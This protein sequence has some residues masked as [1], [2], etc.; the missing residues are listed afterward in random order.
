MRVVPGL[1]R[2]LGSEGAQQLQHYRAGLGAGDDGSNIFLK[3]L[4]TIKNK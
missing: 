1:G 2:V 3:N 4:I